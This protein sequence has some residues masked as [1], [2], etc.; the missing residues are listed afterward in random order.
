MAKSKTLD[1]AK[2]FANDESGATAIEYALLAAII[3]LALIP[4]ANSIRT[5]LQGWMTAVATALLTAAAN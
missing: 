3:S 5:A 1:L 2:A 4:G